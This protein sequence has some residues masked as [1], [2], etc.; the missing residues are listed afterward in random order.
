[1]LMARQVLK[2][3]S[4]VDSRKLVDNA[5]SPNPKPMT[6]GRLTCHQ[7]GQHQWVK[8]EKEKKTKIN[9]NDCVCFAP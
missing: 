2:S 7:V 3:R 4:G 9:R 5:D 1:M 8:M 6:D